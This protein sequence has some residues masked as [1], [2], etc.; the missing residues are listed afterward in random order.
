MPKLTTKAFIEALAQNAGGTLSQLPYTVNLGTVYS[1]DLGRL[2]QSSG[3]IQVS[4]QG[5]WSRF[6]MEYVTDIR[7]HRD[8]IE[9]DI[10]GSDLAPWF[11]KEGWTFFYPATG[12]AKCQQAIDQVFVGDPQITVQIIGYRG[13]DKSEKEN[14]LANFLYGVLQREEQSTDIAPLEQLKQLGIFYGLGGVYTVL[15]R[16]FPEPPKRGKKRQDTFDKEVKVY[17]A[18]RRDADPFRTKVVHGLNFIYDRANFPPKWAMIREP[19]DRMEAARLFPNLGLPE[20]PVA[21]EPLPASVIT[22]YW[23]DNSYACYVD[24]K[25]ALTTDN[26]A[27]ANDEG[28]A[29]NPYGCVPIWPVAGAHGEPDPAGRPDVELAGLL[30]HARSLLLMD[31]IYFN[32]EAYYARRAS[33]GPKITIRGPSGPQI[34]QIER[35]LMA[36]PEKVVKILDS[37]PTEYIVD[38]IPVAAIPQAIDGRRQEVL[39]AL[40]L[41][42]IYNVAAGADAKSGQP[43]R[44]T[45]LQLAQVSKRVTAGAMHLQQAYEAKLTAQLKWV[46]DLLGAKTGVAYNVNGQAGWVE[47]DPADIPDHFRVTVNLLADGEVEKARKVQLGLSLMANPSGPLIGLDTFLNDYLQVIDPDATKK[48]IVKTAGFWQG[49]VPFYV[50][51]VTEGAAA[52]LAKIAEEAG[53]LF[54]PPELALAGGMQVMPGV[55]GEP[56][57]EPGLEVGASGAALPGEQVGAAPGS[58]EEANYQMR[59]MLPPQ[60]NGQTARPPERRGGVPILAR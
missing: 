16:D 13:A 55:A 47:L 41:L 15:N 59:Q 4:A 22:E 36:G 25:H 54:T 24:G 20:K 34:D 8:Q 58:P 38:Q 37:M 51:K 44:Q 30:R 14:R 2:V 39:Q 27:E 28:V 42:M 48:D 21:G 18:R 52:D 5:K 35:D 53:L 57:P 46:R 29:P 19:I 40:D 17:E 56:L 6:L 1:A 10:R 9:D 60:A 33:Q 49:F 43:A 23:D 7:Y 45:E 32:V 11:P 50:Q 26:A 3:D 12:F 31:A